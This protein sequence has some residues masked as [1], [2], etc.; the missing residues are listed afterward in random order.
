MFCT[1]SRKNRSGQEQ[2]VRESGLLVQY[3]LAALRLFLTACEPISACQEL[4]KKEVTL[5][6]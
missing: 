3:I 2:R 6:Q 1:K 4:K 5:W